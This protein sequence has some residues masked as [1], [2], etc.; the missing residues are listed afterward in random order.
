MTRVAVPC[1]NDAVSSVAE[2][3]LLAPPLRSVPDLF[4]LFAAAF[5]YGLVFHTVS[6]VIIAREVALITTTNESMWVSIVAAVGALCQFGTPIAGAISDR[7]GARGPL[8]QAGATCVILGI[9]LYAATA[10]FERLALLFAAHIAVSIGLSVV[11]AMLTA[12]LHDCVAEEQVGR[13]SR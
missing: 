7:T 2:V 3:K 1:G 13:G 10:A 6:N 12:L 8:M 5:A 11:Y 9:A 4:G